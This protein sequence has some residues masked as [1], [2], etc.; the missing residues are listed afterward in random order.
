MELKCDNKQCR[1]KLPPIKITADISIDSD[2]P[3]F[4]QIMGEYLFC[5]EKCFRV[6]YVEISE[7]FYNREIIK[8]D[9]A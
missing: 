7:Y 1:K 4:P 5:S 3:G 9:S 8:N 2:I 6:F